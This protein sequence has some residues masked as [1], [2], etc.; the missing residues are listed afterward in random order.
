MSMESRADIN[1]SCANYIVGSDPH[2]RNVPGGKEAIA[3]EARGRRIITAWHQFGQPSSVF[4]GPDDKIYVGV[5]L[6]DEATRRNASRVKSA[7]SWSAMPSMGRCSRSYL[8]RATSVLSE[9]VLR[10]RV[11]RLTRWAMSM[12][13]MSVPI[14]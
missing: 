11:L 14:R 7:A 12:P 10:R 9:R 4:V 8:I 3:A 13:P 6:R 5:A 2:P 1:L